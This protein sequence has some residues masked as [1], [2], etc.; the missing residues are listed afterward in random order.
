MIDMLL[1]ISKLIFIT[2]TN[3]TFNTFIKLYYKL[4]Q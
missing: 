3:L 4:K 1:H 2:I